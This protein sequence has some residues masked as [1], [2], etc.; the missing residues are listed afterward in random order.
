[1]P[2]RELTNHIPPIGTFQVITLIAL[3]IGI[4]NSISTPRCQV[5]VLDEADRMIDL[6]F[7]EEI[8]N[9]LDHYRGRFGVGKPCFFF[10]GIGSSDLLWPG[11]GC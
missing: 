11:N 6:G 4:F 7:E 8:R 1:M 9:T 10:V 5:L 2:S 3:E